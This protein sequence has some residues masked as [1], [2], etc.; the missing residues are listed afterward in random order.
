MLKDL[1][2]V[3]P[4]YN[5]SKTIRLVIDRLAASLRD[6][7]YEI[8]IVDDNSGDK[9]AEVINEIMLQNDNVRLI[10]HSF[11]QG[12]TGALKTGFKECLGDIIIVQ[13]ADLEY[14]PADISR[15][16]APILNRT[17]QVVYGS[18]FSGQGQKNTFLFRSYFANRVITLFSNFFTKFKFSDVETC[19]KAF[20]REII[21]MMVID[22]SRFGF[23]IEVTAK[24][25][26][27]NLQVSEAPITFSGRSYSEGKK[28]GFKDGLQAL[29]Y[30]LKY[31]L[32][33]SKER[34]FIDLPALL[35]AIKN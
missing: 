16:I 14:D 23:E 13:D 22:S 31:N 34:S 4:A 19:Y 2:V 12:K 1:S 33:T 5:E 21:Q 11:N 20:R 17:A 26:K 18:R 27:L 32:F 10:R 9:T 6:L 25:S 35:E 28:I 3:V 8:V 15:V 7:N 24:I 30:I 29:F